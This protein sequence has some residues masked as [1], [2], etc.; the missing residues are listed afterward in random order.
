MRVL[1]QHLSANNDEIRAFKNSQA[2][3]VKQIENLP[4]ISHVSHWVRMMKISS[5]QAHSQCI[6]FVYYL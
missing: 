1:L 3:E 4:Q 5:F 2:Y 6:L